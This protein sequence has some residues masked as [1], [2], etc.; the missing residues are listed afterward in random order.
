[1]LFESDI[2][3]ELLKVALRNGYDK[4]KAKR[5]DIAIFSK[6]GAAI[7]IEFKSP[8][9]NLDDHTNDLTGYAYLLAAKSKGKLNKFYGYLIGSKVEAYRLGG[10]TPFAT[11]RGWFATNSVIDPTTRLAVGELYSEILLYDDVIARANNRLNVYKKR[12]NISF[13]KEPTD[14]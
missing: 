12:L 4:H 6:E 14:T 10:Y 8:D 2:D 5:P 11:G 3:D 13:T 9:E 1:M 7:I